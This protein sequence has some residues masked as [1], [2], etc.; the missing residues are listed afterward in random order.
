MRNGNLSVKQLEK[1]YPV[2]VEGFEESDDG[3]TYEVTLEELLR[4]EDTDGSTE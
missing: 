3:E 4:R 1:L 2:D